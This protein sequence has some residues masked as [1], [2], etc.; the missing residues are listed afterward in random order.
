MKTGTIILIVVILL[1]LGI[2]FYG[3]SVYNL[4]VRLKNRVKNAWSQIEVQ[5]KHRADLIPNLVE[6]VKGYASHEKE[7]FENVTRA[8]SGVL[9][10]DSPEAQMEANAELTSALDRLLVTVEAYPELKA[11]RNFLAL[12]SDLKDTEEK[13]RYSRQFYNDTAMKYNTS[14]ELFPKNIF[15]KMFG[16]LQEPL[17]EATEA[18]RAVP[19][20]SF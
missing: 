6:T 11:D 19:T 12:Q 3:I 15:A 16:F 8:R 2:V 9:N 17:F 18:D 13:I 5:L 20:V 10:A 4:L 14:I 7:V 1:V